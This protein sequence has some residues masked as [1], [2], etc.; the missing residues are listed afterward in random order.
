MNVELK[1]AESY[2][3]GKKYTEAKELL[4]KNIDYLSEAQLKMLE[5]IIKKK[6]RE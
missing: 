1:K 2:W 4:E 5:Y 3:K 6:K